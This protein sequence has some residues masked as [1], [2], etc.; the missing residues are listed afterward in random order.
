MGWFCERGLANPSPKVN[1]E[2]EEELDFCGPAFLRGAEKLRGAPV[3]WGLLR[4]LFLKPP[5]LPPT[6]TV[7]PSQG[8]GGA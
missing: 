8:G 4:G 7:A 6:L 3:K 5:L 1:V 2:I